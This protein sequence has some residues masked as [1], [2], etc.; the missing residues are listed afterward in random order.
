MHRL[1][2]RF[3]NT[4]KQLAIINPGAANHFR[5]GFYLLDPAV[6]G[7]GVTQYRNMTV[8]VTT[9]VHISYSSM[10]I[11]AAGVTA[12]SCVYTAQAQRD[13]LDRCD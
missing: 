2:N 10:Y 6:A 7:R 9:V 1:G 8:T 3:L 5:T 11:F 13:S 12:A 4:W